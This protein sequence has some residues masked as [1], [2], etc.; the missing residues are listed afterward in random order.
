[1]GWKRSNIQKEYAALRPKAVRG[2]ISPNLISSSRCFCILLA[3]L[4]YN[5]PRNVF[6][7][8]AG[9]TGS[10]ACL[11]VVCR[12][13]LLL[14]TSCRGHCAAVRGARKLNKR[15]LDGHSAFSAISITMLQH[16]LLEN[17]PG[18]NNDFRI[19]AWAV[20]LH[21]IKYGSRSA[22]DYH[23]TNSISAFCW[24]IRT[25]LPDQERYEGKP[26]ACSSLLLQFPPLFP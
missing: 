2:L 20:E 16:R 21:G 14:K 19:G 17:R 18:V 12:F 25:A 15:H 13:R 9:S 1:M 8:S 10:A 24:R 6:C 4:S 11:G 7:G 5:W 26:L 23:V 3:V 22:D